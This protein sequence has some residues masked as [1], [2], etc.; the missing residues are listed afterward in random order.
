MARGR[1]G[2]PGDSR[3]G[4]GG[5]A[6]AASPNLVILTNLKVTAAGRG[7]LPTRGPRPAYGGLP[8][9][10]CQGSR[11]WFP[12]CPQPTGPRWAR[13]STS[14]IRRFALRRRR[15]F[16]STTLEAPTHFSDV[17]DAVF[18]DQHHNYVLLHT[19][20]PRPPTHPPHI[21]VAQLG[22]RK[23]GWRMCDE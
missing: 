1:P 15:F 17:V 20:L 2:A 6:L 10:A 14:A 16:D 4:K 21:S 23:G 18:E 11:S 3:G 13:P 8:S 9:E 12:L 5:V 22:Q 19:R 7:H